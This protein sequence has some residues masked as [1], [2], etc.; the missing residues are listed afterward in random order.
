MSWL[1]KALGAVGRVVVKAFGAE[2]EK[3]AEGK[4]DELN[5]KAKDKLRKGAERIK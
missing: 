1:T 4:L 3:A 2:I 5:E